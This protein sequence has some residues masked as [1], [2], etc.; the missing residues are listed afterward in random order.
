MDHANAVSYRFRAM[1]RLKIYNRDTLL[2]SFIKT[3]LYN[4]F[5]ITK[6]A[7]EECTHEDSSHQL[8]LQSKTVSILISRTYEN[9]LKKLT[10]I[11]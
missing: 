10:Q 4:L 9:H 11:R 7:Y 3:K 6:N 5:V 1:S 8:N 2:S